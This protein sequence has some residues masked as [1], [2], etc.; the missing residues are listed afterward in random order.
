MRKCSN[1]SV[2]F[3]MFGVLDTPAENDFPECP[4]C[5]TMANKAM[6]RKLRAGEAIDLAKNQET[7]TGDYLLNTFVEGK[8]YCD[9]RK[10]FWIWSI[11]RHI[12]SGFILAST[13]TKF[14]QNPKFECLF[15]R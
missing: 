4:L 7:A 5:A 10:E 11:G 13:T 12:E 14:Y 3:E 8:D 2:P 1:C 9:S 6:A 15:L